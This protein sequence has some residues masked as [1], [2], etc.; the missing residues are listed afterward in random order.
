[1]LLCSDG[2]F[3]FLSQEDLGFLH[4]QAPGP[5]DFMRLV[6]AAAGAAVPTDNYSL[7]VVDA[8]P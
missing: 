6:R 5:P 4:A 7:I 2:V 3:D 1:L 8:E